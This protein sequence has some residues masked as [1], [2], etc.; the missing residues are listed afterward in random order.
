MARVIVIAAINPYLYLPRG[1][2]LRFGLS[3]FVIARDRDAEAREFLD[4]FREEKK[5]EDW[6]QRA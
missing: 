5:Q 3:A 6:S 2:S 1:R 4:W